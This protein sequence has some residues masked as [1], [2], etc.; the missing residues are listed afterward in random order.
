[1][2]HED[3]R[4]CQGRGYSLTWVDAPL[5]GVTHLRVPCPNVD[6]KVAFPTSPHELE[7]AKRKREEYLRERRSATPT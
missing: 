5:G 6:C 7:W 1:M 2:R 4:F 3:C